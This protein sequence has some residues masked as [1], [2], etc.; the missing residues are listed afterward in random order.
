M[1]SEL[2]AIWI[3]GLVTAGFLPISGR[4]FA[5]PPAAWQPKQGWV[6]QRRRD[7][8]LNSQ[9]RDESSA[10]QNPESLI[11]EENP[12]ADT[13]ASSISGVP[14]ASV[15]SALERLYPPTE[16]DK[17]TALSRT[18]GYWPYLSKGKNPPQELTYG[19]FDFYFF[20]GLLDRAHELYLEDP[21]HDNENAA[22]GW[23]GKTFVD[24][25]SGTG[26]LVFAAAALHPSWGMSRG[27]ELLPGIHEAAVEIQQNLTE[28]I[29]EN[30]TTPVLTTEDNQQLP[31]APIEFV[32][33]SFDDPYVYFGDADIIFLFSTCLPKEGLE[34]FAEAVGRQCKP[35]TIVITTDYMLPLEGE[36]APV[37]KDDR[38]SSG[39]FKISLLEKIDGWVWLTG[40]ASTAYIQ[41]VETS[42]WNERQ[43]ALDRPVI[44]VEDIAFDV[45]MAIESGTLTDPEAFL[46]GVYNNMIFCG[47]PES[48]Y[49]FY[50]RWLEKQ[51]VEK[52][53]YYF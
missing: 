17:R 24:I 42:L 16:L 35:G 5:P 18:D 19:E 38:F 28:N 43:G 12:Y 53:Q 9:S 13:T 41:R 10:V 46:R 2:K 6:Q 8:D 30:E 26:R 1:V 31:L 50:E 45:A 40:G 27:I 32:C 11:P 47:L 34:S 39:P 14:Y 51:P 48:F 22:E 49:R 33:G 52:E 44:P 29:G 4:A 36:V 20:A 37:E 7:S 15:Q 3:Y 25:G 23:T 21:R